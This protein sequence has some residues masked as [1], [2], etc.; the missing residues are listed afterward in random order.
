MAAYNH[1]LGV[2]YLDAASAAP[3]GT[4]EGRGKTMGIMSQITY[5]LI[6]DPKNGELLAVLEESKQDLD[7]VA[8]RKVEVLRKQYDQIH[9][10]P[11]QE[12]VEYS[13]LLNDAEAVW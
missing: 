12:Y 11:A 2:T 8:N 5:D 9:R 7:A 13:V 10:I 1:V 6:A 4:Y 3:K